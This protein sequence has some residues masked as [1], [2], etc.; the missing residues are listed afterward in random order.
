MFRTLGLRHLCVI[1]DCNR[2]AGL[3]TRHDLTGEMLEQVAEDL[4]AGATGE[5]THT[6]K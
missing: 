1:D 3:I 6:S 5:Y 2:V 4:H